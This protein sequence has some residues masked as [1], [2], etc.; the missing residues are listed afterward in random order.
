M[1]RDHVP[2]K[3]EHFIQG[4]RFRPYQACPGQCWVL[5]V[6]VGKR[7]GQAGDGEPITDSRQI[8]VFGIHDDPQRRRQ[9]G[10]ADPVR[11]GKTTRIGQDEPGRIHAEAR[12][13]LLDR[14]CGSIERRRTSLG[15]GGHPAQRLGQVIVR[16]FQHEF[17]LLCN[18]GGLDGGEYGRGVGAAGASVGSRGRRVITIGR[19]TIRGSPADAAGHLDACLFPGFPQRIG[20]RPAYMQG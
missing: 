14:L 19:F 5:R 17:D 8:R 2:G 10:R 3:C 16:G 12:D 1:G 13:S 9:L 11:R 18:G 6:T 20:K 7:S 4:A 15:N